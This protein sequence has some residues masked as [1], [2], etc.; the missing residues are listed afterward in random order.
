MSETCIEKIL[1]PTAWS[2]REEDGVL[3]ATISDQELDGYECT[4][5]GDE[6]V[7]IDTSK[8]KYLV[9]DASA[10]MDIA[11]LVIEAE[12]IYAKRNNQQ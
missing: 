6:C 2:I 12:E 9:L 1:H 11:D 4:F 10:L 7:K 3:K 5:E 8:V